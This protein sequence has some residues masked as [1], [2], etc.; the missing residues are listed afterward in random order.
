MDQYPSYLQYAYKYGLLTAGTPEAQ[1][2]ERQQAICDKSLSNGGK[3][4]VDDPSCEDV[5]QQILGATKTSENGK[6]MCYNMYDVRLK[7]EYP[8][9]GMNW[10]PD[11]TQVTPYLRR[12]EVTEAL[13][14]NKEKHA[15]WTECNGAVGSAFKARGSKPSKD[16]LPGLLEQIPIMLFSGEQDLICNHLGTEELINNLEF[17]GGKGFEISPGVWAPRRAWT[18]EGEPAGI[19]QEAR[20]LTYVLIHNSSHMVPFDHPRRTR[21][22]L[23]RFMG[24]DISSIGGKPTDSRIDGAK[25][26]S[27]SVGAH[28]NSTMAE[29]ET[30]AQLKAAEWKAYRR[31]GELA[32]VVVSIAA[33][34]WFYFVWRQRRKTRGYQGVMG[35]DPDDSR[36]SRGGIRLG[37][38]KRSQGG[39]GDIEAADFA[40]HELEDLASDDDEK[41]R[42]R[43]D[44]GY[45]IGDGE[46]D[47]DEGGSSGV[48]GK[49]P[50]NGK[51]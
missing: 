25:G 30:A 47:S 44:N 28:P 34:L 49:S 10:P 46:D 1:Q 36:G 48:K 35:G 51:G 29:K 26:P 13:H 50:M 17:N 40:E 14:V 31:A 8:S 22:M 45:A 12:R 33:G 6:S 19:Y 43:R 38:G 9:C 32:L 37:N 21:D 3:D 23:D 2:V 15:G 5:L 18:F 27:T 4:R 20:N 7:D 39:A 24:V 11:L 42:D 16:L 41:S